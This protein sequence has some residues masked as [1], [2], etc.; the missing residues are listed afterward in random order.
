MCGRWRTWTPTAAESACVEAVRRHSFSS[1]LHYLRAV[2]LVGLGR[3]E[4]AAAEARRVLYLDRSLAIAHCLLGSTLQ[5]RRGDH[6]GA[7][8]SFRNARDL[9]SARPVD[10]VVPL[11]DGEPNGRLAENARLQ[12]AQIELSR[13][14]HG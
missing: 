13:E 12:M 6:E 7:W 3:D 14:D 4:E 10:E 1:E 11:S 5:R 9:C 8:R 2:L